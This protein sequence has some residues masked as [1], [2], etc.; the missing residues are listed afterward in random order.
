MVIQKPSRLNY[1]INPKNPAWREHKV[2][3]SWPVST[4]LLAGRQECYVQGAERMGAELLEII[5]QKA[6]AVNSTGSPVNTVHLLKSKY[7]MWPQGI[8]LAINNKY[9]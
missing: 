5:A 4:R 8:Q 1:F 9:H 6:K 7:V 3:E 2:E